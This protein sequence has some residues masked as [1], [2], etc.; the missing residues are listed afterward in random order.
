MH[1]RSFSRDYY[2]TALSDSMCWGSFAKSS[3]IPSACKGNI[4]DNIMFVVINMSIKDQLYESTLL[5]NTINACNG[6]GDTL[7]CAGPVSSVMLELS[8]S[9]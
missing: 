8:L 3:S 1:G 2:A 5:I 9:I 7:H 4:Y 6:A